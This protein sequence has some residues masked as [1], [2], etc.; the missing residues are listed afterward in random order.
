[1]PFLQS[2][3]MA[4]KQL[5]RTR[6]E[7]VRLLRLAKRASLGI[8]GAL[9]GAITAAYL[10]DAGISWFDPLAMAAALMI[11]GGSGGFVGVS[12]N[13]PLL[14]GRD[15]DQLQQRPHPS[16]RLSAA[17]TFI[18][19]ATAFIAG[20][21]LLFHTPSTVPRAAAIGFLSLFGMTL[22]IAAGV[23]ARLRA[24]DPKIA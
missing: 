15:M 1:M 18:A 6:P 3:L 9:N 13:A 16:E 10:V 8:S 14:A 12:V 5:H 21:L 2:L 23:L 22:Q 24:A 17:G 19:N 4:R 7:R 20:W 11:F